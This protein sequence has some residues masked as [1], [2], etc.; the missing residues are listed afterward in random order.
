MVNSKVGC[1]YTVTL[2]PH[3]LLGDHGQPEFVIGMSPGS[4]NLQKR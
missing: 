1:E 4:P 3:L 2:L